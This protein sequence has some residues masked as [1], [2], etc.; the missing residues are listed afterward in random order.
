MKQISFL[1]GMLLAVILII[2]VIASLFFVSGFWSGNSGTSDTA[3][4]PYLLENKG[5]IPASTEAY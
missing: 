1:S 5:D 3:P 2:I 4:E